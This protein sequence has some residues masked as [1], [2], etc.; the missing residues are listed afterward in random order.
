MSTEFSALGP[1]GQGRAES[2][3]TSEN[4]IV[5]AAVALALV[6]GLGF[7]AFKMG[8][9]DAWFGKDPLKTAA[10]VIA[11]IHSLSGGDPA[12]IQIS[13]YAVDAKEGPAIE[14]SL[15]KLFPSSEVKNSARAA[16]E[17]KP[18]QKPA[19]A[20][21]STIRLSFAADAINEAWPR[22]RFGDVKR[23]ELVWKDNKFALRGA[24]F[25]ADAK[26]TLDAAFAALPK[27]SQAAAQIREVQRPAVPAAD[28]QQSISV[29]LAGRVIPFAPPPGA[30][31]ADVAG[32]LRTNQQLLKGCAAEC[33]KLQG[34]T[35]DLCN[36]KCVERKG[37]HLPD[38]EHPGNALGTIEANDAVVAAL[39]PLLKDL[40]GLEVW[41]S[42]GADDRALAV[43]QAEAVKA[44]LV[45]QGADAKGLKAV[46]A[47]KNNALSLIVREKE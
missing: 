25:S 30:K 1:G 41:I 43:Q 33:A 4:A 14:A 22:P 9:L 16:P 10:P 32:C 27:A 21:S 13:G 40:A 2:E 15:R 39:A 31:P 26:Q 6:V 34:H 23:L 35:L 19:A 28:L 44:A 42:A 46:P 12:R 37:G 36:V 3:S 7:G 17:A 29:A 11:A 38:C 5:G 45:A 20:K 47:A 24:V 8:L 18:G